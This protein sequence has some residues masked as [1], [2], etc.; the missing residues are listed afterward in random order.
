LP[1]LYLN[2]DV[3]FTP[4][5]SEDGFGADTV[6]VENVGGGPADLEFVGLETSGRTISSDKVFFHPFTAIAVGLSGEQFL[7]GDPLQS[8]MYNI[9]V[10]LYNR[11]YDIHYYDEDAVAPDGLGAAYNEVV[12]AIC[13]RNVSH[14]AIFG[15]SHGG[16]A[17]FD[18]AG[19]LGYYW[20][21]LVNFTIDF[22]AYV[23]AIRNRSD[24]DPI[25]EE[26]LPADTQYHMNYYQHHLPIHG[27]AVAGAAE[28]LD[29]NTTNWGQSLHHTTIDND[30]NVIAAVRDRLMEHMGP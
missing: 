24:F 7:G 27:V 18:L 3:I 21:G 12:A 10:E 5:I 4:T 15:H 6:W 17:T 2:G 29:V 26:H 25:A 30:P 9:A 16:G 19:A 23:D 8:G 22:T 14:V 1:L 13:Y 28:N 20:F 11:G